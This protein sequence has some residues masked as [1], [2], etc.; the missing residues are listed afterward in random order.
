MRIPNEYTSLNVSDILTEAFHLQ[1]SFKKR[2]DDDA[3]WEKLR[4][5]L[6]GPANHAG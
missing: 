3:E 5:E 4:G 6:Q 2:I 1:M